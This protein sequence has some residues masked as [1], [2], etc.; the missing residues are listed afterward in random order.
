M[1][2]LLSPAKTLDYTPIEKRF[3]KT[4]PYFIDDTTK[5]VEVLRKKSKN[6]L[7]KLMHISDN[8]A[9]ENYNRYQSFQ[10]KYTDNNS[11]EA[12]FAFNGDVYRGFDAAS[13]NKNQIKYAQK[14][15]RILSGLYGILKPLDL[16]QP[17]RLE[18]G[19]KLSTRRGKNLYEFWKDR[20]TKALNEELENHKE[21]IIINAAS[22][23]YFKSIK[24]NK[25]KAQVINVHFKEY[26][27]DELKFISFNAKKARGLIARY[28]VVNKVESIKH[29]QA[30]DYE[31]Y[32]YSK[33]HSTE[34]DLMFIR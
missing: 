25:L 9:E 30:F 18:M 29:L 12:I 24:K 31:D 32:T 2:T 7:K 33:E 22:N 11:K 26:H 3:D 21:A 34:N 10:E 17:Y 14:H 13:L 16:M 15:I 8:I 6:K 1:I 5:L 19:T 4:L 20:I 27:K 28:I 23:E